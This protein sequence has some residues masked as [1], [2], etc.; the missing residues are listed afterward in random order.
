MVDMRETILAACLR[1]AKAVE[2]MNLAA[3]NVQDVGLKRPAM[4][5]HDGGETLLDRP[6]AERLSAIQRVDLAPSIVILVG[7]TADD[8]GSLLNRF[9][10]RFLADLL[11]DSEL[12]ALLINGARPTGAYNLQAN[13]AINYEGCTFEPITA[14]SKEGR[15][16][17][18]IVFTYTFRIS[19]LSS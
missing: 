19:D 18:N 9:R 5:I 17:L 6:R 15:M 16:E 1:V 11:A 2:G 3:R 8:L 4:L 13:N 10:G 14:E 12:K 7:S